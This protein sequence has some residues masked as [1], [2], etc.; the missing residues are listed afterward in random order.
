MSMIRLVDLLQATDGDVLTARHASFTSF[1]FDSRLVEPGQLFVAV[2]TETGDGHDYIQH[3]LAGG[4]TGVLC[5]RLPSEPDPNVTWIRVPNTQQALLDYA[6]YILAAR[7]L[8]VIGIAGSVGKTTTKEVLASLLAT[9]HS[10]FRNPGS[11]NGRFGLPI[12]LGYMQPEHRY[13]VLELAADSP[14]EIGQM[15]DIIR[16][17]YAIVTRVGSSH[18]RF[19]GSLSR[20]A[21]EQ[22][23]LVRA[24]PCDGLAVLNA[25]DPLVAAMAD[26][27]DARVVTYGIISK[28]DYVGESVESSLEGTTLVVRHGHDRVDLHVGLLGSHQAYCVLAAVACAH[29]L[30]I[31]WS[32]IQ[33][34]L[35]SF[36]SLPGRMRPLEGAQGSMLLDDTFSATPES[37]GAALEAL[38]ALPA[39]RRIAV[40][41][42]MS[43]LGSE[44][45]LAHRRVGEMAAADADLLVTKGELAALAAQAASAAGMPADR[46]H[47]TYSTEDA[48]RKLHEVLRSGDLVLVKGGTA[49]R[50]EHV[51][52]ALLAHPA[53]DENRVPRQDAGWREV[54]MGRPGRPTWVEVDLDAIAVNVHHL[55]EI[56]GPSVRIM[57]VLKADGYGHGA[58]KVAR[59]ALNNGVQWLGVACLGEALTLREAGIEAPILILGYS[60]AWQSRDIVLHNLR[61]TVFAEE[62]AAALNRAA[63]DLGRR[64]RVHVKVDTG[65]GRLGLFPDEAL[66]LVS[67]LANMQHLEVE[68]LFTHFADADSEDL[69]Y[70]RWQLDRFDGVLK[71]LQ[72]RGL[73]PPL[74]HA[75]NSAATL[76]LS[77]SHYDMVRVGIA[78]YGLDPSQAAPCPDGFRSAFAFKCEVAQVKELP[79]GHY[80]SYGRTYRTERP[81]TVAIIPVGYADGFRR[82]PTTWQDVL[83][84][85]QRAPIIGRV[86]MDQTVIDVSHIPGVRQGDQVVLIGQQGDERITVGEVAAQLGTINYEVVS[87]I[88]ARVPR[89]V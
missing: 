28:G 46:V 82:A 75:A 9:T 84:R 66:E 20:I 45:E 6:R 37:M 89:V 81:T 26:L 73:R 62:T 35:A 22:A 58:V 55:R 10:T 43:D 65:M 30:G 71:T 25:D 52:R 63:R 61:A 5:K 86:C 23:S 32:A 19:F 88:L 54:Q 13:A 3:A 36:E 77:C 69:G 17:S 51:T 40:L 31:S 60:P 33:A 47:V 18:L 1:A 29:E 53:R 2:V 64:A 80:V 50:M 78:L 59:T 83:V 27:T 48:V 68:G 24:L 72:E 16:P 67:R 56:V 4:A 44:A 85:G 70:T 57:A 38:G 42:D 21:E 79:P 87:E 39:Q 12:A 76:R 41:G 11:Y 7:D 14:N 34:A 8:S 15:V 49:A 74:V